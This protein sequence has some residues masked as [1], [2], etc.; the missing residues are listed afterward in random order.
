MKGSA[1]KKLSTGTVRTPFGSVKVRQGLP[2]SAAEVAKVFAELDFQQAAQA[3]LWALPIVS[4]AEWQAT[5]ADV[6]GATDHDIVLYA[7]YAG[8]W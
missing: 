8:R 7:N 4:W 2:A 5:Q 3:Y 6:F 1:Q